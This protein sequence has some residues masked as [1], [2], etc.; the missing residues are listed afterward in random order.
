MSIDKAYYQLNKVEAGYKAYVAAKS[1]R[2]SQKHDPFRI[3][4]CGVFSSGKSTLINALLGGNYLPTGI[5]PVTKVVTRIRYGLSLKYYCIDG[6]KTKLIREDTMQRIVQGNESLPKGYSELLIQVPSQ[7]LQNDV[8]LVDTPGYQD[9]STL[10]TISRA[11][12]INGDLA[13]MCFNGAI[14]GQMFE[15]EYLEELN[16]SVG[17][18]CMVVNRMDCLNTDEDYQLIKEYAEKLMYDRGNAAAPSYKKGKCF[19]TVSCG[20]YTN[21]NEFDKHIESI[22]LNRKK[23]ERIKQTTSER[24]INS[25]KEKIKTDI[26]EATE[27]IQTEYQEMQKKLDAKKEK[28]E[29]PYLLQ[30]QAFE[31]KIQN[32][33]TKINLTTNSI[34]YALKTKFSQIKDIDGPN[35]FVEK[36]TCEAKEKVGAFIY[37]ISLYAQQQGFGDKLYIQ[38]RIQPSVI[39]TYKV[40][41]PKSHIEKR[42]AY[43]MVGRTI[44]TLLNFAT[45]N[46]EIDDGS[47]NVTV[48]ND[49]VSDAVTSVRNSLINAAI[50]ELS[51]YLKKEWLETELKKI[52]PGVDN[53]YQDDL[54][55][56]DIILFKLS[57][58]SKAIS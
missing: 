11:A 20:S 47:T 31:K 52:Y 27:S 26:V 34:V 53:N 6:N 1:K 49:Y 15:K 24:F 45:L 39:D 40:P 19:L 37:T 9:N 55:S 50:S 30:K 35:L 16:R 12:V 43:G 33:L 54:N 25:L 3:V 10:E 14:F 32:A 5:N 58:I 7:L 13:V 56:L 18:F 51:E 17:N 2:E 48:Y 28:N 42:Q 8:E 21:L 44:I 57:E 46:F 22:V 29:K 36:A 4:F 41:A 38:N 23:M